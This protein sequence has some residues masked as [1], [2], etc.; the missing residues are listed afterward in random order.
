MIIMNVRSLSLL[1]KIVKCQGQPEI[2]KS[3]FLR[4]WRALNHLECLAIEI[5]GGNVEFDKTWYKCKKCH[6]L[7]EGLE[8]H[9]KCK[10][11]TSYGDKELIKL[12]EINELYKL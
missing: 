12:S 1:C 4:K 8:N 10:D 3:S 2:A 6:K 9:V 11:C 5:V 7:I